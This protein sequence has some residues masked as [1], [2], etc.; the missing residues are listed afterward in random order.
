[1]F[2]SPILRGNFKYENVKS[3]GTNPPRKYFQQHVLKLWS[4]IC[5]HGINQLTAQIHYFLVLKT[6][7]LKLRLIVDEFLNYL[8]VL[9]LFLLAETLELVYPCQNTLKPVCYW[10]ETLIS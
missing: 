7:Q 4:G 2:F 3:L 9:F 10:C 1:M 6:L 8:F 5:R